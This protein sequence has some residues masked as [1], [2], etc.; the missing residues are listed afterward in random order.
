[1]S[2]IKKGDIVIAT[3][4]KDKGKHGKVLR[5]VNGAAVKGSEKVVVEGL[6]FVKK[7][8]KPNPDRGERGGVVEREAPMAI[9]NVALYDESTGKA[10]KVGFKLLEDNKKVRVFKATNQA[11]D[12]G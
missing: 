1:M 5:I 11:V 8:V 3:T 12:K 7:H 4:G 2:K 10:S 6:N 9:S